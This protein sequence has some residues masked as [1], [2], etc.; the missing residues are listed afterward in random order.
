M[1]LAQLEAV[2]ASLNE[3]SQPEACFR[4]VDE[5]L[6]ATVGHK[7]FTIL[8]CHHDT[9]ESERFYTNMPEA[10]PIGGRK[11]ITD[12]PWMQRM[13]GQGLPYI[14][15]DANDIADVF[16]DHTLIHS[17]GCD[18][19]LNMPV[20]WR[21]KT[22]ATFNLLDRAAAYDESHIPFVRAVAQLALPAVLLIA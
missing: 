14:G 17:L 15:Y 5:T 1:T 22:I 18:S 13:L 8:I 12:S 9:K 2:I 11:P 10:Y 20:R 16:Y 6:R 4:A 7:L 19:V 3:T 21:G